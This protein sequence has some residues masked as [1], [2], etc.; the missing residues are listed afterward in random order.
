MVVLVL[1]HV[2]VRGQVMRQHT[3][4]RCRRAFEYV[5]RRESALD[6]LPFPSLVRRA[7]ETCRARLARH[8]ASDVEPVPCPGCGWM[9][10]DMVRELSRRYAGGL[11]ALGI[12]IMVA[13]AV[14]A[15]ASG[16]AGVYFLG[17]PKAMDV[18]WFGVAGASLGLCAVGWM[19]LRVRAVMGKL[20]YGG[21]ARD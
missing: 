13:G 4:E 6:T 9:G 18:N 5:V 15:L 2:V 16:G 10:P 17:R 14:L 19:M 1:R 12:A 11:R 21:V 20:R 3:C 8:L 7:E